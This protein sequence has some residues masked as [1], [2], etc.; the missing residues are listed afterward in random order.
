ML[1]LPPS[2]VCV[3]LCVHSSCKHWCRTGSNVPKDQ[4]DN[5]RS[6]F[7]SCCWHLEIQVQ[8]FDLLRLRRNPLLQEVLRTVHLHERSEYISLARWWR[9][10]VSAERNQCCRELCVL[11][12]EEVEEITC[13]LLGNEY[14]SVR[15]TIEENCRLH[16]PFPVASLLLLSFRTS[17]NQILWRATKINV[18]HRMSLQLLQK[19]S[20]EFRFRICLLSVVTCD[21]SGRELVHRTDCVLVRQWRKRDRVNIRLLFSFR[22]YYSLFSKRAESCACRA[23]WEI[24]QSEQMIVQLG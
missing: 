8:W 3:F 9:K 10:A 1:F 6:S 11:K 19:E 13:Q 23:E 15:S 18:V 5:N 12:Q 2:C 14:I 22:I 7:C 21:E 16:F 20:R 24:T 4:T 17:P